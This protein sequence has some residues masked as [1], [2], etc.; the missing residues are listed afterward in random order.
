MGAMDHQLLV[1]DEVTYGVAVT[2][3]RGFEYESFAPT[4]TYGR[5]EGDPLRVGSS[6]MTA[7]RHT[8]YF[9][10]A[11]G[12]LQ[13]SVMTKGFAFWLEHML[14]AVATTGPDE[15]VVYTH[16]G[17]EGGLYGKSLTLQMNRPFH[18][19]GTDQ[20]FLYSG[21]KVTDW[22]LSNS[23]EGNLL[24]DL[25]LDFMQA[26]TATG[27][28]SATYPSAMDNFTWAGGVV[29]IGGTAYDVTEISLQGS[30]GYNVDRR[31]I[32]GNTDKKEPTSGRREGSFSLSADF[33]SL[34][35]R[36]RAAS[37]VRDDNTAALT[38]TWQGP[39][40][41]GTTLYP[42]LVVTV[43]AARFDEWSTA[44]EGPEGITQSL[45]G[46]IRFNRSD[47]PITIA[48]STADATP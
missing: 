1:K 37:V 28:A 31:Q 16:T 20:P 12:T 33:E 26:D 10:G 19:S 24:L 13:M 43:P 44:S 48:Y 34:A 25:G 29:T 30:N 2:P 11:T 36:N 8:P 6:Y 45:S 46:A 21:G 38:A 15:T 14:G 3:D 9:A 39:R 23:V 40:L 41:L 47:S 27:L 35:Q 4:E 42:Q 17:T 5:T 22:T 7:D 18:P 32:R